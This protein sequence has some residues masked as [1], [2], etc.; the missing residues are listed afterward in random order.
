[1]KW[2]WRCRAHTCFPIQR[3]KKKMML[4]F[5][6]C[7]LQISFLN[8]PL[9][10]DQPF[11][12]PP[13]LRLWLQ[14][15]FM[16]FRFKMDPRSPSSTVVSAVHCS[17]ATGSAA[18]VAP[19]FDKQWERAGGHLHRSGV[20]K[21]CTVRHNFTPTRKTQ[22]EGGCAFHLEWGSASTTSHWER[23]IFPDL[24]RVFRLT[25]LHEASLIW[26]GFYS[27]CCVHVNNS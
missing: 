23:N 17:R 14:C 13:L 15:L 10:V 24:I 1:M 20:R 25:C 19:A 9:T 3:R 18:H 16:H 21:T 5:C 7:C 6:L 26:S 27:V 4:Y 11:H 22:S 8:G 12:F 2:G